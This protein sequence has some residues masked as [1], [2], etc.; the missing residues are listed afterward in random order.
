MKIKEQIEDWKNIHAERVTVE[1]I[2]KKKKKKKRKKN[3]KMWSEKEKKNE[4]KQKTMDNANTFY[5]YFS[6]FWVWDWCMLF[7]VLF[8][9]NCIVEDFVAQFDIRG[10]CTIV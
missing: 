10:S 8:C 3:Q 6:D 5:F 1:K 9:W 4:K 2:K 7:V